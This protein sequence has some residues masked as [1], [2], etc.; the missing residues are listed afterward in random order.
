MAKMLKSSL[1]IKSG[2]KVLKRSLFRLHVGKT[3]AEGR[4]GNI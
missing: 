4:N 1:V 2:S 3:H